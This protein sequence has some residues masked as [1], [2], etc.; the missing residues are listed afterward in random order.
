MARCR[1]IMMVGGAQN[2]PNPTTGQIDLRGDLFDLLGGDIGRFRPIGA[3]D[4]GP[5][6][7]LAHGRFTMGHPQNPFLVV[8]DPTAG[9]FFQLFIEI[10]TALVKADRFGNP[11]VGA[12]H[13]GVPAGVSPTDI[14]ALQHRQH[15]SCCAWSAK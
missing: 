13:G 7:L 15:W 2:R 6:P 3:I 5:G 9:L 12:N 4:L 8:H 10:D 14:F 11:I 1:P